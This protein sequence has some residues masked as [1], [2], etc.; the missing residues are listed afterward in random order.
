MSKR[1]QR[2]YT[3]EYRRDA[4]ALSQEIGSSAAAKQLK[5]PA[6]TLYT[7]VSRAK[8]GSLPDAPIAPQPKESLKMAERMKQLERENA[9][10]KGEITQLQKERK[11]LEDATVFFAAR[12]KK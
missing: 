12:Q 11:I 8:H 3:A 9:M 7:W 5:I 1:M 10:L 4:V 6:E 2:S